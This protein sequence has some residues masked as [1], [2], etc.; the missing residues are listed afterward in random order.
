MSKSPYRIAHILPWSAIGGTEKATLRIAQATTGSEFNHIAFS[1]DN[2][3]PVTKMFA[4]TGFETARYEQVELSVLYPREFL[5]ASV[6]LAR[7]LKRRQID[8]V[9]FS[10]RQAAPYAGLAAKLV[11]LPVISHVRNRYEEIG[12]QDERFL[13]SVDKFVFVS[14]DTWRHFACHVPPNRGMV[15]YDGL[16]INPVPDMPAAR[17]G[18]RQEF[19]IPETSKIIGM[20]ARVAPQKDYFTLAKAAA[21]VI[22]VNRD[23]RFMIVGEYSA[24]GYKRDHYE[25]VT[26]LL[27]QLNIADYFIFTDFREDVPRL[28]SSMDIFVLS[29][30]YEGLPLV[31][32]EA[33]ANAKPVVATAV[34]GIPEIVVDG[35]T[36]LLHTHEDDVGLAAQLLKLVQDEDRAV[37]LGIAGQQFVK[38]DFSQQRFAAN[39]INLYREMLGI[40]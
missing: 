22:A 34:D 36:G 33:M 30:H 31:L 26:Q 12:K 40:K 7:E 8:L 4:D 20:V 32:I 1:P 9:H 11:R 35:K 5:V 2:P 27:K 29:T 25:E 38:T 18:V 10:D 3:S 15:L 23:V 19:G 24:A 39:V 17:Q 21:R 13:R 6:R 37:R 28:L 16:D 14:Q